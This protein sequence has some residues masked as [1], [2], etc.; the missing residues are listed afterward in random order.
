MR[1]KLIRYFLL[2]FLTSILTLSACNYQ[3]SQFTFHQ[4]VIASFWDLQVQTWNKRISSKELTISDFGEKLGVE[5]VSPK[6]ERFAANLSFQVSGKI[7]KWQSLQTKFIKIEVAALEPKTNKL[8]NTFTYFVPI[9]DGRFLQEIS[10][11][12][13]DGMYQVKIM[14]PKQQ[15]AEYIPV[16]TFQVMNL[17]PEL[18]LDIQYTREA[19]E[20]DWKLTNPNGGYITADGFFKLSGRGKTE[21]VQIRIRKGEETWERDVQTP[22]GQLQEEFPLPYGIGLYEVQVWIPAKGR[23]DQKVLGATL[24]VNNQ[25]SDNDS[26]I[27]Y[28]DLYKQRGIK[29]FLPEK[30]YLQAKFVHTIRGK[31][32]LEAPL[33][34]QTE[35][36]V[37]QIMKGKDKATYFVP[38]EKGFFDWRVGLRFGAGMYQVTLLVP[39]V[40]QTKT[41]TFRFYPVAHWKV[42]SDADRDLRDLMPSRGIQ[43]ASP[44]IRRIAK[45]VTRGK[46]NDYEKVKAIYEFVAKNI[47]YDIDKMKNNGYEWTDGALKTLITR[48]GV[49]QDF[50]FLTLALL[51][52][53]DLPARFIEGEAG[54]QQHA[55]VEAW[56]DGRW[57]SMDPTWGAGILENERFIKKYEEKYFDPTPE[58]FNKTH[59]RKGVVY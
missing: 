43:S 31:I 23:P 36:V 2:L 15:S 1:E 34:K 10:L 56:V 46:K 17:N 47:E 18:A 32:D 44:E 45:Q 22:E 16:T 52:S 27:Q 49:C 57:I 6:F 35:Y 51:R 33:A 58:F 42:W 9:H 7:E 39:E 24:Y 12:A 37:I 41:N 13:R 54:G 8:P 14:A 5:I 4:P 59:T 11:F 40:N 3:W 48:K 19:K 25:L 26:K 38:V 21:K 30:E 53:I 20:Q 28:T 50:S 55:W 29:L